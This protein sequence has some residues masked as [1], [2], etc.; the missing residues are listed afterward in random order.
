MRDLLQYKWTQEHKKNW[1]KTIKEFYDIE[2]VETLSDYNIKDSIFLSRCSSKKSGRSRGTPA[3]MYWGSVN[4]KFYSMMEQFNLFY[5]ICSDK[6][7]VVFSDEEFDNYDVHPADITDQDK[8][9][10]GKI[11]AKKLKEKGFTGA[12]FFNT[13][14][15]LSRPYFEMLYYSQ[16]PIKYFSDLSLVRQRFE[17]EDDLI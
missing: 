16:I 8:R 2:H 7:G 10:L 9:N 11:I 13:S 4:R 3:Q 1:K 5:G 6:L 17:I 15:L 12:F 14:P